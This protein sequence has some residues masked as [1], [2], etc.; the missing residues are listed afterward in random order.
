[1][2]PIQNACAN[3]KENNVGMV[4]GS[5]I[6]HVMWAQGSIEVSELL[7]FW[8]ECASGIVCLLSGRRAPRHFPS[9]RKAPRM[10]ANLQKVFGEQSSNVC[11][12]ESTRTMQTIY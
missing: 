8:H 1:M 4:S 3:I 6:T 11:G 2:I 12:H 5:T 10:E 7:C 9:G